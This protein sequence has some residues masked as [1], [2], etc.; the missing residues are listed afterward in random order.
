MLATL[1]AIQRHR[2]TRRRRPVPADPG[3]TPV[4]V[5]RATLIDVSS[6]FPE[7]TAAAAWLKIAGPEALDEALRTLNR[8]LHAFRLVSAD[9]TVNPVTRHVLLVAR[10]GYGEGD[11]VAE[12]AWKEAVELVQR[13]PRISR[14][15]A[16][17]PQAR[18]AALLAGR[19][20][21]LA[22]EELILRARLD[23]DQ[24]R[25]REAALQLLVAL[26]AALAE[27]ADG[28]QAGR[29]ADCLR[30]LSGRR[31]IAARAAQA[32]LSGPLDART[33]AQVEATVCRLESVLR[34]RAVM[35]TESPPSAL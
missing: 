34:A 1:G 16:L 21:V 30:E 35:I 19:E 6:P 13:P 22:C 31:E 2:L 14:A 10:L 26:D 8:V 15:E 18:L 20:R 17:A 23:L 32:A 7:P 27:L 25:G 11:Q 12:G 9:P 4:P 33:L 29:L 28:P 5:T 24:Q 3:P